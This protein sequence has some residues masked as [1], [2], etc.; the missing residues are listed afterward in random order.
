MTRAQTRKLLDLAR[1]V[2]N[3]ADLADRLGRLRGG[4]DYVVRFANFTDED[5]MSVVAA[6]LSRTLAF[7]LR[8]DVKKGRAK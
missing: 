3:A 6:S 4:P 8:G 1:M 2:D 5:H 7:A